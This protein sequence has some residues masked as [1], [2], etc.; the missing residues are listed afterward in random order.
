MEFEVLKDEANELKIQFKEIDQG[1]L[2]LVKEYVWQQSGV[3]QAGFHV[4]HPETGK[5]VFTI[6]SKGKK[7]KEIWNSA[8]ATA[9]EDL[10][11]FGKD[12][13]KLK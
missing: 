7:A 9:S 3:E 2:N 5:P 4:D 8:L 10:E 12:V 1:F 13:K 11:K 6:K